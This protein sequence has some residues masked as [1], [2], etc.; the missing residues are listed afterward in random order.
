MKWVRQS[1]RYRVR[2]LSHPFDADM[3]VRLIRWFDPESD[4]V[5]VVLFGADK[6]PMGDVFYDSVGSRAAQAIDQWTRERERTSMSTN[7]PADHG[8][9]GA[10]QFAPAED[11]FATLEA[12]PG[13]NDDLEQRT[14]ARDQMEREHRVGLA[15]IRQVARL[16][17][18]EVAEK[19]GIRQT[20]VSR[21]EG[22]PDMLLSTM[23][24]Y[25]D[26]VGAEATITIR[27]GAVE[28]RVPLDE[29]V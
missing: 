29:L 13:I 7:D 26:A 16:T 23:K 22:R 10:N 28:H 24:A 14:A 3:A 1:G 6:A 21:L 11:V 25:F 17:Q 18:A 27:V 19:M 15:T 20:S 2:R 8:S 9:D 12:I 5:V 4:A